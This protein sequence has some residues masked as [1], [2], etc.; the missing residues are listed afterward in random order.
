M[1][2]SVRIL[3]NFWLDFI[4]VV[5]LI[6]CEAKIKIQNEIFKLGGGQTRLLKYFTRMLTGSRLTD[7]LVIGIA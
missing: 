4:S 7:N 3:D 1:D 5:M 6:S 2:H